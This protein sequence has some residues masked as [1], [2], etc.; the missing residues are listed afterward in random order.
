VESKTIKLA[1]AAVVAVAVLG[2]IV[3]G[4]R[5]TVEAPEAES[6]GLPEQRSV[7]RGWQTKTAVQSAPALHP[8]GAVEVPRREAAVDEPRR[9]SPPSP[10]AADA[11]SRPEAAETPYE[12]PPQDIPSLGRMALTDANPQRRIEAILLLSGT[13]DPQAIPFLRQAL[14][15]PDAG[16][17]LAVVKSLADADFPGEG[18]TEL[19]GAVI[20]RDADEENRLEALN[21]LAQIDTQGAAGV[22][23]QVLNDPDEDVRTRAQEILDSQA[24]GPANDEE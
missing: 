17:R 11:A 5:H 19:L 12:A 15:D 9:S 20:V 3:R 2:V 18:P 21:V 7:P 13:E 4:G 8:E 1:I 14:S 16:V 23:A 10:P 6:T 22:A 24:D